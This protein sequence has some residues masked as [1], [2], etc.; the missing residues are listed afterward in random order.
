[1]ID[2]GL[3]FRR[4]VMK[5]K[6][7]KFFW[8]ALDAVGHHLMGVCIRH[9]SHSSILDTLLLN[10]ALDIRERSLYGQIGVAGRFQQGHQ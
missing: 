10:G 1:M 4:L 6:G 9:M 8:L 7:H 3:N 2:E 5:A